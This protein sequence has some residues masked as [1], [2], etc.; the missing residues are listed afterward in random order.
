MFLVVLFLLCLD[1]I[2]GSTLSLNV[3]VRETIDLRLKFL[4][5]EN[6][7]NF[8]STVDDNLEFM[9]AIYPIRNQGLKYSAN[10]NK[11][12]TYQNI[13]EE[14]HNGIITKTDAA[15]S[16]LKKNRKL[17]FLVDQVVGVA[18]MDF[19]NDIGFPASTG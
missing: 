6:Q 19:F 14:Y 13:I 2:Q 15:C 16:V 7:S 4:P 18:P 12:Y 8:Q 1:F 17:K 5:I 3:Y 10:V 11:V 9:Q